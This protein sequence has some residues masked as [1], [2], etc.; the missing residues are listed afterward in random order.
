MITMRRQAAKPITIHRTGLPFPAAAGWCGARGCGGGCAG[1]DIG[2]HLCPVAF[3]D[4]FSVL[5]RT[6][7]ETSAAL[8]GFA[9][10]PI[11]FPQVLQ[12]EASSGFAA[13]Q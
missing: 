11:V 13:P 5:L 2:G 9:G 1:N 12:N 3:Q 10:A 7:C 4:D 8:G 6:P